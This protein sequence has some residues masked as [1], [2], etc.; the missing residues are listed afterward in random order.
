MSPL[1]LHIT[2][3]PSG[4]RQPPHAHDEL[5]LTLVLSGGLAE[6]VGRRS[7]VLGPMSVLSKDPGVV[8]ADAW[9]GEGAV[10]ARLSVTGQGLSDIA[11]DPRVDQG[12]TWAHDLTI[13]TPFLRLVGRA[14]IADSIVPA[15]DTD[16][17]DLVAALASRRDQRPPGRSEPPLW[18]RDAVGLMRD[19][20]R[21]GLTVQDVA[22]YAGVHAV[23]LARCMRRWYGTSVG[24]ELRRVRLRHAVRSLANAARSVSRVAHESGFADEPHLCRSLRDASSLTPR[25]LRRLVH[26]ASALARPARAG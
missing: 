17:L 3:Y 24:D 11:G 7:A 10:L 14:R 4:L 26:A 5:H 16:V 9:G 13:A 18:L 2:R 12:W 23:Y 8:H 22:R 20:W 25:H 15:D 21:P 19:G 1:S 6:F